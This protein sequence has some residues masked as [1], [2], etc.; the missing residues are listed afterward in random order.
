MQRTNEGMRPKLLGKLGWTGLADANK[1]HSK[2][3]FE[4]K[5]AQND[6]YRGTPFGEFYDIDTRWSIWVPFEQVYIFENLWKI[7]FSPNTLI[8]SDLNGYTEAREMTEV[9]IKELKQ[10][11]D[12]AFPK[13][14]YGY[15]EK[16]VKVYFC[17]FTLKESIFDNE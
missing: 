11:L 1:R 5:K 13:K 15:K 2:A 6:P 7:L 10:K 17:K 9:E 16:Y 14:N 12:S 8:D 4:E 3:Y